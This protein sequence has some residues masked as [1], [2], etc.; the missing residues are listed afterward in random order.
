[1]KAFGL[2]ISDNETQE[3]GLVWGQ[4]LVP[5]SELTNR[6]LTKDKPVSKVDWY[7]P[8]IK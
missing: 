5:Y 8:V 7:G 1:M 4:T 6:F 3:I 2:N